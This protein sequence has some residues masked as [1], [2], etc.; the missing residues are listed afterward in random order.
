MGRSFCGGLLRYFKGRT[1]RLRSWR[2]FT[3]SSKWS[4]AFAWSCTNKHSCFET[5]HLIALKTS[6][7]SLTCSHT[8]AHT[9]S[10]KKN[11]KYSP[12]QTWLNK[13]RN[14]YIY[15]QV[16]EQ[17]IQ[18]VL[19]FKVRVVLLVDLRIQALQQVL[20][21]SGFLLKLRT[22][23]NDPFKT[24]TRGLIES[25]LPPWLPCSYGS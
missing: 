19:V 9:P 23:E 13:C 24:L 6:V 12:K 1:W 20:S 7:R 14:N 4:M 18:L 22:A 3:R 11:K 5:L 16:C 15:I 10:T 17:A 8:Y 21:V 25:S 2:A